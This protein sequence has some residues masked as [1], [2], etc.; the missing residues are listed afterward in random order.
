[1][2]IRGDVRP[3]GIVTSLPLEYQQPVVT[4]AD[5]DVAES[6]LEIPFHH[7][8]SATG[9]SDELDGIAKCL[10]GDVT[11]LLGDS[12]IDRPP[13]WTREVKYRP[14]TRLDAIVSFGD[15][16]NRGAK[17]MIW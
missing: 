8:C 10:V 1:L 6:R 9:L 14:P 11:I 7:D 3:K 4:C 12:I 17:I 2:N 5:W 15:Q 13:F 16:A